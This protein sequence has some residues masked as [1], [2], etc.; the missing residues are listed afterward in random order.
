LT[1]LTMENFSGRR[2]LFAIQSFSREPL[3]PLAVA[4]TGLRGARLWNP[5][6]SMEYF[7][8]FRRMEFA[9][10]PRKWGSGYGGTGLLRGES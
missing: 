4:A 5:C 2:F 8:Y 10:L 7:L 6:P 1:A 9:A 3:Q